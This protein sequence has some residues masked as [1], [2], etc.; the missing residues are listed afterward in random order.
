VPEIPSIFL[1]S[2]QEQRASIE[3]LADA[4]GDVGDVA[5]V[6]WYES[7]KA[8]FG[9]LE[10]LVKRIEEVDFAAFFLVPDDLLTMRGE[11][12]RVPRDNIVFELGLFMGALNRERT[13][14]LVDERRPV[15]LFA[16]FYGVTQVRYASDDM[17][18]LAQRLRPD[19]TR[20][21]PVRRTPVATHVVERGGQGR[22][23]YETLSSAI[24]S[25]KANDVILVRPG[26]YREALV[27]TKPLE[28][29]GVGAFDETGGAV[30][31]A[32]NAPAVRYEGAGGTGRLSNLKIGGGGGAASAA[33]DIAE[34]H[35]H[36]ANCTITSTGPVEACI[37]V[38]E[39]ALARIA[40]NVVRDSEGA[41]ILVCERAYASITGN[42][43]HGHAHS[44]VEI[45][46]RTQP[47]VHH[48]RIH[49]GRSGGIWLHSGSTAVVSRNDIHSNAHSGVAITDAAAPRVRGNRIHEGQG[50]GVYVGTCGK[51]TIEDND[52]YANEGT[53]IELDAGAEPVIFGNNIYS[54]RGGGVLL[55]D[56]A[57]GR[58][59]DNE[60]RANRKA[61]VAFMPG[62]T[63]LIF[64]RNLIVRGFAEGVYDAI[65]VV[66]EDNK[67]ERNEEDWHAAM[68]ADA[69]G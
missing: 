58:I 64:A 44:C 7:F 4:L 8:G 63:S 35:L 66:E 5:V 41:G 40:S 62:S 67:V 31:R 28:L 30:I 37:R 38:R 33:I 12:R 24:E 21:G 61:G 45:R 59:R 23:V 57:V 55:L 56:G 54:G 25:A 42:E 20:L 11:S 26:I 68:A 51:G 46:D 60:I 39:D 6:P 14:A 2:S 50:P 9:T 32:S 27:I 34:G 10:E 69:S 16:D 36:I 17:S 65:G 3:K 29:I 13:F 52:I 47:D 53:G 15:D 18:L 49:S 48:N 22:N 19:I 1:G 43:I